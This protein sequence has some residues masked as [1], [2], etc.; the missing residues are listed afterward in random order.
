MLS[1]L[2]CLLALTCVSVRGSCRPV[3]ASSK[4]QQRLREQLEL[5]SR[6]QHL[7]FALSSERSVE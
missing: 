3:G 7:F 5:R 4:A 1:L 2:L 6:D